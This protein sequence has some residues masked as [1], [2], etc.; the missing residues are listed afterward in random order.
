MTMTNQK[1]VIPK[2]RPVVQPQ[3]GGQ[4]HYFSR[5]EFEV[6]YGGSAGPGKSWA[7]VID[8][9]GLQFKHGS[10]GVSAVQIPDYR[11][12][13]FRRKTT[14]FTKLIDEGKKYY[15]AYP[16]FAE[17]IQHRTGDPGPSFNFPW[18]SRIFICHME[19]EQNKEDHQGQ[20]YQFVGFDELTQFTYTQY[21]YLFSRCRST[22]KNLPPRVRSTTN[23]TGSGLIWVRKRFI[24]NGNLHF[25]PKKKYWFLPP[26]DEA[27]Y[28]G[29]LAKR[30]D[31]YSKSRTFVPGF[32]HENRILMETDPGYKAN[33]MAMGSQYEKALLKGDWF[34]FGGDFFSD[35][36][37]QMV[38][39]PFEIPAGWTLMGSLDPGWSSPCSFGLSAKDLEG[40]IYRLLTYYVRKRDA[41]GHAQAIR[42]MI[43]NFPWTKGRMPD[44]I[45]S[46]HDAWAKKDKYSIQSNELTLYDIFSEEGLFLQRANTSRVPGWWAWKT[47]MRQ[48]KWKIFEG[49]N[50]HLINEVTS[51]EPDDRE[52]EDIKG[53]GNDPDVFDHALDENRYL[54]MALYTP[55]EEEQ[56]D[57]YENLPHWGEYKSK[58][59]D[60]RD[61]WS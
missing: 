57:P 44:M 10:L 40:N 34:A 16:F 61:I 45:V 20:E 23:P 1:I 21:M 15:T 13:L 39:E 35:F 12:V 5:D 22:I 9:L 8:A 6:L 14:Q 50:D 60:I 29:P 4:Q 47:I 31:E 24:Q 54:I 58:K 26:T 38:V 28:C 30:D 7:L 51:A 49:Y 59:K 42:E 25:V 37:S 53:R 55:T 32:L 43:L 48:D 27:D 56:P 19:Q 33:I 17:F 36:S 52:P 41:Y 2:D 3:P 46:G 18:G 11:A